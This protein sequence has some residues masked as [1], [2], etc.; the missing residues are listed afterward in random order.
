MQ[1]WVEG[2]MVKQA[3]NS[4]QEFLDFCKAFVG[5]KLSGA[6]ADDVASTGG[7]DVSDE[8]FDVQ[9]ATEVDLGWDPSDADDEVLRVNNRGLASNGRSTKNVAHLEA[10]LDKATRD[11]D[12]M[13]Q[14]L[15][16]MQRSL[17]KLERLAGATPWGLYFLTTMSLSL[18]VVLLYW[19][20]RRN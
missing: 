20:R 13:S 15:D 12:A 4:V 2:I 8:F 6:V 14:K 19:G 3:K 18:T 16:D 7:S 17:T 10:L 1:A 11:L 5:T 9:L